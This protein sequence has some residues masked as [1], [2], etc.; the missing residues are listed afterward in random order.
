[1]WLHFCTLEGTHPHLAAGA[2]DSVASPAPQPRPAFVEEVEVRK[3]AVVVVEEKKG[4]AKAE[5][6][7]GASE[8]MRTLTEDGAKG[9]DVRAMQ[10]G[11]VAG[12]LFY[13]GF[14]LHDVCGSRWMRGA[15][16]THLCL[17]A[18]LYDARFLC[19]NCRVSNQIC[20]L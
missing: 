9:E 7:S 5:A 14:V 8:S 18:M 6:G 19:T 11:I 10:V 2:V 1:M 15:K 16:L 3:E 12:L 13:V 4:A 17:L 20:S